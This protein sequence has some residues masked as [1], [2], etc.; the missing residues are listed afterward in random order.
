[1]DYGLPGSIRI[2][3]GSRGG[4]GLGRDGLSVRY[5]REDRTF[6]AY[7]VGYQGAGAGVHLRGIRRHLKGAES[8]WRQ[9]IGIGRFAE[10]FD[11]GIAAEDRGGGGIGRQ[12][13]QRTGHAMLK[14]V[15]NRHQR[16]AEEPQEL[17]VLNIVVRRGT[18]N[19]VFHIQIA[20]TILLCVGED[21]NRQYRDGRQ[22]DY[23]PFHRINFGRITQFCQLRSYD[24]SP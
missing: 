4:R 17:A 20:L 21:R 14:D 12:I 19:I 22:A 6:R 7:R 11:F 10:V 16:V 23:N 15:A 24:R 18:L 2:R 9:Q 1:M 3:V 8:I 5:W 13:V